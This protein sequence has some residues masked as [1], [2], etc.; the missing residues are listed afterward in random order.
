MSNNNEEIIDDVQN[1]EELESDEDLLAVKD[2][3]DGKI[4][5]KSAPK[6]T[7]TRKEVD[8][9]MKKLEKNFSEIRAKDDEGFIDLLDPGAVK[10]KFVRLARLNNK[11]V[12]GLKDINTDTY[13]DEPIYVTNI[14]HPS[15]KGEYV[16]W[17]TFI[18]EDGTE[19][20][21]PYLSFMNRATG[22]WGEVIEEKK[23]DKSR[24]FG[25]VDI[26]A[27]DEDEWDMKKTGKKVLAKALQYKVTYVVKEIKGG[28]TLEVSEDV[29]NKVEAPY[30]E[31]DSF[32]EESK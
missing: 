24:T 22:V 1:D 4:K 28:K 9:L 19:E 14:E 26:K 20:T 17:A 27:V 15:K 2:E 3:I 31:L 30:A 7:Y 25:L 5:A 11:F 12:V 18:Y 13:S 32:L 29:I 23:E 6:D 16:P 10:R 8:A 21:Y